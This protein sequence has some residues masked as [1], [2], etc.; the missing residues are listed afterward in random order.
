MAGRRVALVTVV[1]AD[2]D[3]AIAFY[4]ERLGFVIAED[5]DLG[6][7]K[8]WVVGGAR[9]RLGGPA[10]SPA[11]ATIRS[12]RVSATR[13]AA[14]SGFFLERGPMISTAIMRRM[15]AAGVVFLEEPRPRAVRHRRGLRRSLWQSVRFSFS[16]AILDSVGNLRSTA[17]IFRGRVKT[18]SHRPGQPFHLRAGIP[19]VNIRQRDAPPGCHPALGFIA[20]AEPLLLGSV[21]ARCEE[22][23]MFE[24]L[25]ERLGSILNGLTG[26][27]A[28]SE[29]DVAAALREVRRALIEADVA[30]EV[31]RSFTDKVREKAVGAAVLKSIKP[32]QMVVKI[33]P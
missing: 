8:R 28:L 7:G 33:G 5:T 4:T 3:E 9:R 29:Q 2:Y 1:V 24:N 26:R 19:E 32:G 22:N 11:L 14:G 18:P 23:W 10:C 6:G 12:G 21:D 20:G 31:V 30:L 13:P 17:A 25:Q 27:G 15:Q 16:P